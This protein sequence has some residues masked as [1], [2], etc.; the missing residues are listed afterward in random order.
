MDIDTNIQN[1]D[2]NLISSDKI[3]GTAVYNNAGEKLGTISHFMVGKRDGKVSYAVM[4]FGGFLGMGTDE[5]TLPWDKLSYDVSKGGYVVD[6]TKDVLDNA[7]KFSRDSRD[8]YDRG[9]YE[10]VSTHYGSTAPTW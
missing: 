2:H 7:P 4:A 8:N 1:E 9:Y 6:I 10:G 5:Y 3:E